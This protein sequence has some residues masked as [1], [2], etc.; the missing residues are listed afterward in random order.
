M[1][2]RLDM[3]GVASKIADIFHRVRRRKAPKSADQK[4]L[5]RLKCSCELSMLLVSI[6]C[7]CHTAMQG[8]GTSVVGHGLLCCKGA[9]PANCV[10]ECVSAC[11]AWSQM[12]LRPE[13]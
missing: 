5:R 13:R 1:L 12:L 9:F 3:Q 8:A 4:V 7:A 10:R 11:R 6:L 2:T